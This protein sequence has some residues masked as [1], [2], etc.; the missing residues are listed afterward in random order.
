MEWRDPFMPAYPSTLQ[1]VTFTLVARLAQGL[2]VLLNGL[3]ADAPSFDVIDVQREP[4]FSA[5]LAP[6]ARQQKLSR[7]ITPNLSLR[8]GSRPVR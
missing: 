8:D 6:H 3:A 5:G 4:G 2:E 1:H 7:F